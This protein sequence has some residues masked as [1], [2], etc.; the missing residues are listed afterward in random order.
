MSKRK[1]K[2]ERDFYLID[3][4]RYVRVTRVL[5]VINKPEFIRWYAKHGYRGAK[6]I[7]ADRAAFGTRV[8]KEIFN[9]LSGEHVWVDNEEMRVSL[10]MFMDWAREHNL[11]PMELEVTVKDDNYKYA[12]TADYIGMCDGKKVLI[13]WK[14]SKALYD[15]YY[16]QI[17][18][19]WHAYEEEKHVG[20][21]GAGILSIRDGKVHFDL[22][23]PEELSYLF[24]IFCCARQLFEWKYKL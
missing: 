17:A 4:K 8:H 2:Q 18:A 21:D 22:V 10:K 1:F 20:L 6:E 24:D 15:N 23:C 14:T 11:V 13:D 19:Y 5:D 7:M 12:G 3:N 16:L 9:F